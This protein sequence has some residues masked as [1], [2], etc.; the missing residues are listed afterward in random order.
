MASHDI[1]LVL[2]D[3]DST[4]LP[5]GREEISERMVAAMRACREA[6]I[7][8]A[9]ATGRT[10]GMLLPVLGGR[11]D[12][13]ATAVLA[14]GM[15]TY[16][17]GSVAD[18]RAVAPDVLRR[19]AAFVDERPGCGMYAIDD[20][21][22]VH[23]LRGTYGHNFE[24]SAPLLG[25][26]TAEEGPVPDF[27]VIKLNMFCPGAPEDLARFCAEAEE[28]VP[29]LHFMMPSPDVV[30]TS[31]RGWGKG[32]AIEALCE[33]MG[34]GLDQAVAFGD[35]GNDIEMLETV[36]NS[37]AVA[38]ATPEAKAAARYEIG[39]CADDAVAKALER[40]AAREWP[41]G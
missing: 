2:T 29:E 37:V 22:D 14:N 16:L 7:R 36:P 21:L 40:L 31:L 5:R 33:L 41:F 4:I 24:E 25:T 18:E 17:D 30:N 39:P 32:P 38:N 27:P 26:V 19:L 20:G 15:R 6:G 3:I 9:A 12:L 28:A 23:V 11:A 34:I 35:A 10:M 1:K 13:A 8:V